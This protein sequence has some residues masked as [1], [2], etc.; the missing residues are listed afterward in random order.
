MSK[1]TYTHSHGFRL[2]TRKTPASRRQL[3]NVPLYSAISNEIVGS[4]WIE[5][6]SAPGSNHSPLH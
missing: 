1:K 6:D 2:A 5:V 3:V 4:T